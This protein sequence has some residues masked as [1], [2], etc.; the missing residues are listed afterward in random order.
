MTSENLTAHDL[1]TKQQ[2]HAVNTTFLPARPR[3]VGDSLSLSDWTG[4]FWRHCSSSMTA[5]KYKKAKLVM[6]MHQLTQQFQ[7]AYVI[8]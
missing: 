3:S 6:R 7:T 4:V 2:Q 1:H 8:S 5:I